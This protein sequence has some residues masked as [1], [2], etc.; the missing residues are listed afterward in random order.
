MKILIVEDDP[1]GRTLLLRYLEPYGE[2]DTASDGQQALDDFIKAHEGNKPYD[3]ICLDIDL[4]KLDGQQALSLMRQK[5][6]EMGIEVN[7]SKAVKIFMTTGYKDSDNYMTAFSKACDAYLIKPVQ[8]KHLIR[9][10][11]EWNLI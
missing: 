11:K 7:S 3:L 6:E 1:L 2:C 4:P 8:K 5:E 9:K 10:M